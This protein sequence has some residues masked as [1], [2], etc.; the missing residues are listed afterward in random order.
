MTPTDIIEDFTPIGVW[1]NGTQI[2]EDYLTTLK[3]EENCAAAEAAGLSVVK[4]DDYTLQ[5][6]IDSADALNEFYARWDKFNKWFAGEPIITRSKSNKW[7]ITIKTLVPLS[8]ETRIAIQ[9]CLGSDYVR[10]MLCILRVIYN[11][12]DPVILFE[13][14]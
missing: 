5:L 12:P 11:V 2:S 14:K 9:A 8:V 13:K 6:D 10:E 4:A 7:H 1:A 3:Q